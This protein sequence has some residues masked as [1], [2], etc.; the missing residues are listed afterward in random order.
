M[1][2]LKKFI[3]VSVM[4]ALIVTVS[5]VV[6]AHADDAR[7][8]KGIILLI[9]DG[10]GINQVRSAEI[11]S[12]QIMD[13]PLSITS[14]A[15]RGTTTTYSANSQVT[16]SAA[17]ATALYTGHKTNNGTINVLPDGSRLFTIGHAAKKA[18]MSVGVLS[19]SRLT[20]A[21]PAG[22][23]SR[24]PKREDENFIA[25]QLVEFSPEVAMAGGLRHF[26]PQ[27]REGSKRSDSKN[28]VDMM[29]AKGY[30]YVTS[31]DDLK[32]TDPA[33]TDKLFGLFAMSHLD[34]DL[35][36]Q[37]V[38]ELQNQP[39]LGDMTKAALSVLERNPKGFFVMI[40]GGRIDHACH[41]HDIKAS[42]YET[43]A[44]DEAVKVALDYQ[45]AHPDVLV[46]VTADHE[47]G[48]LG[49]G[50]GM[51]YALDLAALKPIKNSL[52][53]VAK[54]VKKDPTKF[55]ESLQAA[56]FEFTEKEK[57]LLLRH[58]PAEGTKGLTELNE[59]P[60]IDRYFLSWIQY[61]LASIESER[62]KIG[63]TSFVHTAQ[64]VMTYAVGPHEQKFS[65]AYDNTDIP[66]KMAELLK[67]TLEQPAS[68]IE[69][70]AK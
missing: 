9:G 42:I 55:E 15:T 16:D 51:E 21:T 67:V 44:F 34:Y 35:D 36:R 1:N 12:R 59:Y 40:E 37:N 46:L 63:W 26:I 38:P 65:G 29:K 66:K 32:A 39:R 6:V 30:T 49:L 48:G 24:S 69:T 53:Y 28:L 64:P 52:D 14:I 31:T 10:M 61:S 47:T 60:K 62:A 68:S 18:G 70:S 23:Y 17:A 20:D 57:A 25:E 33:K 5:A 22:V 45:K 50:R 4:I 8:V 2:I 11:Y 56:G 54:K 41:S 58:A 43:L 7:G 27:D 3:K 19:T 13:K